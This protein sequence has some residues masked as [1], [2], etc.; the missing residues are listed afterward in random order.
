MRRLF[1]WVGILIGAIGVAVL[2][3]AG[4]VYLASNSVMARTYRVQAPTVAIPTDPASIARGKYLTEKVAVCAD[5]HGR[6]LGGQVVDDKSRSAGWA[7]NGPRPRRVRRLP[8]RTSCGLRHHGVKRDG[9]RS[10]SCRWTTSH[11][12]GSGASWPT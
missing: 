8:D 12:G 7:S 6:D 5:C 4:Y 3:L 2:A 10:S 1:K 11:R 9:G